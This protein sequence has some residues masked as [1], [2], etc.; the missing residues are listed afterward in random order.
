MSDRLYDL[1]QLIE[2]SD[3]NMEF[4]MKMTKMFSDMVYEYKFETKEALGN[5][6]YETIGALSHKMKSSIDMMGIVSLKQDIRTLEK[7]DKE[8]I[9]LEEIPALLEQ[10]WEVLDRV[11]DQ[12]KEDGKA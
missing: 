9:S 7:W 11:C 5:K 4:V 10:V 8:Q 6:A 3:G 1:H 12:L 2:L